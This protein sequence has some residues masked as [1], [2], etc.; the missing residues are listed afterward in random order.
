[1]GAI[2]ILILSL[3]FQTFAALFAIRLLKTKE[4]RF[5]WALITGGLILM[6]VQRISPL[7]LLVAATPSVP[8]NLVDEL[9]GMV[10]SLL[11]VAGVAIIAPLLQAVKQK[12][13]FQE[14]LKERNI[15]IQNRVKETLQALRGIHI[16]L[17]VEKPHTLI[18]TQVSSLTH[19]L[20]TFKEEME[21]G[22]LVGNNFAVALRSLIHDLNQGHPL[23]ISMTLNADIAGHLTKEQ[24]THLLHIVREAVR[25]VQQH[26]LAKKTRINLQA[27]PKMIVMEIGDNGNGFEVYLVEAQG[28]GLGNMVARAKK[29]DARL[30]IH[31]RPHHGTS[32]QVEIPLNGTSSRQRSIV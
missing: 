10:I 18:M 11:M 31:S 19:S 16:A 13:Q 8:P 17:E 20:Q 12:D 7:Y 6:V 24:G 26:A 23:P 27:K 3:A 25:N 28:H 30:K 22:L 15:L 4:H 14:I 5:A 32:I 9:V 2:A 29:I 1:M 21:S